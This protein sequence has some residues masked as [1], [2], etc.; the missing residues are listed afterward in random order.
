MR[1]FM[2]LV[3]VCGITVVGLLL[4]A[5][6]AE[7]TRHPST[8]V[9]LIAPGIVALLFVVFP[10]IAIAQRS[11]PK[12]KRVRSA[13]RVAAK[14]PICYENDVPVGSPYILP[15]GER[16]LVRV[17]QIEPPDCE[18]LEDLD[19]DD[20]FMVAGISHRQG[21]VGEMLGGHS[22][23][24]AAVREPE[25]KKDRNAIRIDASWLNG[26]GEQREATVGYIQATVAAAIARTY[27]PVP[28]ECMID[29][30]FAPRKGMTAGMR[31][32]LL[33]HE[34]VKAKRRRK[35]RSAGV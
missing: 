29:V 35:L 4:K 28:I 8:D 16:H 26:D 20:S 22:I 7:H 11:G 24:V 6:I 21:V 23:S 31:V 13:T 15:S 10:I 17:R 14:V 27:E 5:E 19:G 3:M 32:H 30:I 34:E 9:D 2:L 18:Y 1:A 25:N 33:I 12:A